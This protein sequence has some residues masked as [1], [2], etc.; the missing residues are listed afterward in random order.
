ME[1]GSMKLDFEHAVFAP[2]STLVHVYPHDSE[3]SL[4]FIHHNSTYSLTFPVTD[5]MLSLSITPPI[6]QSPPNSENGGRL[7]T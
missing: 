3:L 7:H 4:L 2:T 1:S 6:A 5:S